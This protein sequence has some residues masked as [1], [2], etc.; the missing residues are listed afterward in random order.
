M[1]IMC[2]VSAYCD[3]DCKMESNSTIRRW[4]LDSQRVHIVTVVTM[5]R[6]Y[7]DCVDDVFEVMMVTL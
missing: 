3:D 2:T 5:D 6:A 4:P 1:Y 7:A